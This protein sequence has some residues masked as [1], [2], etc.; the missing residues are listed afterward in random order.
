MGTYLGRNVRSLLPDG[1]GAALQS[2]GCIT[3]DPNNT[4]P[5]GFSVELNKCLNSRNRGSHPCRTRFRVFGPAPNSGCCDWAATTPRA[6]IW[7]SAVR[8]EYRSLVMSQYDFDWHFKSTMPVGR[9]EILF[10]LP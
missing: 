10:N 7:I 6:N 1:G 9:L 2:A 8:T 4:F 5:S 3:Q